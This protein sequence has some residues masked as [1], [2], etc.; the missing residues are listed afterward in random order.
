LTISIVA[1]IAIWPRHVGPFD[2]NVQRKWSVE[3][4]GVLVVLFRAWVVE[5]GELDRAARG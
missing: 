5:V 3:V 2:P 4:Q 1:P